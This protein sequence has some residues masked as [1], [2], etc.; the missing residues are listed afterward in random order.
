LH[1]LSESPKEE[2]AR[3]YNRFI[4]D[5]T[6]TYCDESGQIDWETLVRFNSGNLQQ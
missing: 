6:V 5:F 1:Y 3:T 4:R 2:K